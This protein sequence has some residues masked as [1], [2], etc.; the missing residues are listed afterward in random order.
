MFISYPVLVI[1][2]PKKNAH[3]L[4]TKNSTLS[5]KMMAAITVALLVYLF[6]ILNRIR[7]KTP[8]TKIPH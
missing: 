6:H 5:I 1:F 8:T 3:E 7:I 4:T 2:P